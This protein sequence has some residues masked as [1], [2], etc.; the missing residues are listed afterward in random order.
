[1]LRSIDVNGVRYRVADE[2]V[3]PAILFVH[4]FPL[5]HTMWSA[6]IVKFSRT[7]RVIAPDLRGFG[8]TDGSLYS[9]SMEQFSDDLAD[10]LTALQVDRPVTFC[11]LSMGGYIGWQFAFRHADWLGRLILCDTRAAADSPEAAAN[12]LKMADIVIKEGPE[13]VAWAMMP[14]LFAAS[15]SERQPEI[16]EQ[17]RHVV[18]ATAPTA[19][20]AAHRGMAVRRDMVSELPKIAVPTLIVV[21]EKDAISPPAEMK[22]IADAIPGAAFALIPDAG[23]MAPMENPIAVNAAIREFLTEN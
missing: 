22:A 2:G 4:G 19:I 9:V 5:D 16:I 21:G 6:Q 18:L 10:L 8:G 23:H 20:A 3:G 13:P 11:G 14:K 7:H 15:T 12:R 1:M 17:V